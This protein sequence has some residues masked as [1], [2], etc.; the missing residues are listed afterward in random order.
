MWDFIAAYPDKFAAAVPVAGG[1]D[2]STA[3][4]IKNIPIWAYHSLGDTTVPVVSLNNGHALRAVGGQPRYT[5]FPFGSHVTS[6]NDTYSEPQL[7]Q[8]M[9]S[10]ALPEPP[11]G[12]NI[13]LFALFALLRRPKKPRGRATI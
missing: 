12:S 4:I 3:A 7:Y 10:Q 11:T 5:E 8:W 1:G 13:S 6:F 2:P 9:Y